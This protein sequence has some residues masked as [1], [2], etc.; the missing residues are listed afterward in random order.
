MALPAEPRQK[1][2]N[3][4]YLVLTAMLALNVSAEILNAFKT[5]D[6]SLTTTNNTINNSTSTVMNSFQEKMNRAES[7]DKAK[8]WFPKAKQAQDL[9]AELNTYIN[10]LKSTILAGAGFDPAKNGDSTFKE[11]NQ[12]IATRI[13]VEEGKGKELHARLTQYKQQLASIAP[14][15]SAQV[16]TYL[17]Q[18]DL[19][20]PPSRNATSKTWEGTYF[21]MVPTVAAITM[22]SK[23]QNDIKTTENHVVSLFHEQVGKVEVIFDKFAPIVGQ[24]TNYLMPG[25]ELTITAGVGA[26]NSQSQP[27]ISIGGRSAQVV[28]GVAS[29]TTNVGGV[30]SGSVPISIRYKD[31]NG[32]LKTFNTEAKYTVG[33]SST[34]IS[35]DKMNVLFIGVDNPVT[36][37]ASGGAEQ[38]NATISGGGGSLT[39]VGAGKYVARVNSVTDDCKINVSVGGKQTGA[40]VFRVRTIPDPTPVVGRFQS[41]ENVP[42]SQFRVQGGV[43]AFLKDFFF[44]AQFKVTGFRITGD[45]EG[46]DDLMEANVQ[47]NTWNGPAQNIVNRVRPGSFITIED[48]RCVGPDGRTRKLPSLLFNVK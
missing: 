12:D 23:F 34:S 16:N 31:Q 4:M 3:L 37:A 24:S 8:E 7:A 5:V 9:T 11:D 42:A 33:Q 10:G 26:F 6:R 13:M 38:I 25:Q 1:M 29:V 30:G 46:F 18:I 39:K 45:G 28:D 44:D 27:Q 21:H 19:T 47:G 43:G 41:G 40:Q 2:I 14:Q 17:Q 36:I 48:I 35:L 32:Q 15:L 22:L 20:T